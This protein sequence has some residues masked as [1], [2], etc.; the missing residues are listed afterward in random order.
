MS[1]EKIKEDFLRE[2]LNLLVEH[3][4][5]VG[6]LDSRKN[7]DKFDIKQFENNI[8]LIILISS[9]KDVVDTN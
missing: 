8:D 4:Y 2:S 9:K 7:T 3:A 5:T 6:R 1:T